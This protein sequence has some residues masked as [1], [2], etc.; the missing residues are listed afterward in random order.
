MNEKLAYLA[1]MFDGEGCISVT[2]YKKRRSYCLSVS[3]ANIKPAVLLDL[4]HIFGGSLSYCVSKQ[5][6]RRNSWR[7][8]ISGENSGNFLTAIYPYLILKKEEA[9]LALE[10]R[11]HLRGSG[12][13]RSLR[14]IRC[15]PYS[16]RS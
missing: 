12:Q 9:R 5:K 13:W 2:Y 1:G 10:F 8:Q 6:N 14:R 15:I 7:W 4:Q 11:T 3:A 16:L